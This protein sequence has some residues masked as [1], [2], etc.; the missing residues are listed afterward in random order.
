MNSCLDDACRP[1]ERQAHAA[2]TS[3]CS[4]HRG[5]ETF[6]ACK[7]GLGYG[8]QFRQGPHAFLVCWQGATN[9]VRITGQPYCAFDSLVRMI[10]GC[11]VSRDILNPEIDGREDGFAGAVP[12]GR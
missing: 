11:K 4:T 8:R 10:Y 5:P 3:R 9:A 6:A 2:T 1:H 7:T 12:H